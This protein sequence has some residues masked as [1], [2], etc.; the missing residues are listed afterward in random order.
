VQYVDDQI[1]LAKSADELQCLVF[2]LNNITAEFS[3]KLNTVENKITL[4][5]EFNKF[6][7]G[8]V[9]II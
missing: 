3:V 2:N 6:Q 1:F 5:E 7:T 4:L 9:L 8:H